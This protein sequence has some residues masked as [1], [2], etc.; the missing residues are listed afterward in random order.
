VVAGIPVMVRGNVN[1]L[2]QTG[3]AVRHRG[4]T[5]DRLIQLIDNGEHAQ[6]LDMLLSVPVVSPLVRRFLALPGARALARAVRRV[7]LPVP[8]LP[9]RSVAPTDDSAQSLFREFFGES[10]TFTYFYYRFGQPRHLATLHF[11]T[12]FEAHEKPVLD[13]GCGVGHLAHYLLTQENK[14]G[15]V[16]ADVNFFQLYIAKKSVARGGLFVCAS[17]SDPLPFGDDVFS[18]I[19]CSDA[20]HYFDNKQQCV[21]ELDRTVDPDGLIVLSR[22]GNVDVKPNEGAELGA[23][24]YLALLHDCEKRLYGERALLDDY[25]NRRGADLGS[26]PPLSDVKKE[27]WFTIVF[28]KNWEWFRRHAAPAEWP[29]AAGKIR[30]NPIYKR[31][32]ENGKVKLTRHFPTE[33]YAYENNPPSGYWPQSA[34]VRRDSIRRAQQGEISEDVSELIALGVLV[35]TPD[36]YGPLDDLELG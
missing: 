4:P 32:D 5:A 28:S 12:L 30:I 24:G 34:L 17:G 29:H 20:F 19:Y 1:V 13:L 36:R 33:W 25:L 26:Q 16:L 18:G 21:D 3:D 6:A 15:V 9:A 23:E 27:K 14:V 22:V 11:L 7:A 10:P 35:G 8:T 31:S 2:S